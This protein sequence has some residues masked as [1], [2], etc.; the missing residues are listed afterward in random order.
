MIVSRWPITDLSH[1]HGFGSVGTTA[2]E[3]TCQLLLAELFSCMTEADGDFLEL[4]KDRKKFLFLM[5][6]KFLSRFSR[7]Y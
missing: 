2:Q 7:I 3:F 6:L 4:K 5:H 1:S